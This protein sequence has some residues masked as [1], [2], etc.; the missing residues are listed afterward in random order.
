MV[1][2][3][4]PIC[5]N[6]FSLDTTPCVIQPVCAAPL[7]VA[8]FDLFFCVQNHRREVY[9]SWKIAVKNAT[10]SA[11]RAQL[12]LTETIRQ[13]LEV[14]ITVGLYASKRCKWLPFRAGE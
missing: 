4:G 7:I 8:A 5:P 6:T 1:T 14:E 10:F 2:C 3:I 11:E 13:H 9:R 12:S